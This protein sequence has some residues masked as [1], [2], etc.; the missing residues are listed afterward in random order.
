M[1]VPE[2]PHDVDIWEERLAELRSGAGEKGR[3]E[4]RKAKRG[5]LATLADTVRINAG[6]TLQSYL[7]KRQTDVVARTAALAELAD[8][9]G[10]DEAPLRIECFDVSH[11]GGENAVA[12]MVVFEDGIPRREHYRKFSLDNPRDD[13]EAIYEVISR[14]AKRLLGAEEDSDAKDD[15]SSFAYPP[16]L[17]VIDGGLP[18][19]NAAQRALEA[20]GV[21]IPVCGLAKRLE[22]IWRPASEFPTILPRSSEALFLLQRVRDEAHRVA[23]TYQRSTRKRSLRSQ[24]HDIPGVGESM[25]NAL[26]KHFGSVAAVKEAEESRLM[27]VPGVGKSLAHRIWSTLHSSPQRDSS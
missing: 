12:S 8:S 5:D 18:Q 6:Q 15:K 14:R 2:L 16:G 25:A 17:L 26:L 19:V 4:V 9:L 10:L 13:T 3:V 22:E 20:L 23:I 27:E 11:L 21:E 1:I 24:L 7:S